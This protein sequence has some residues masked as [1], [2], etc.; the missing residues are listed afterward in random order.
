MSFVHDT[1]KVDVSGTHD[2]GLLERAVK[3]ARERRQPFSFRK[4]FNVAYSVPPKGVDRYM[5]KLNISHADLYIPQG[6]GEYMFFVYARANKNR[7][8]SIAFIRGMPDRYP[9]ALL[10]FIPGSCRPARG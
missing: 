10:V 6:G 7:R 8:L 2:L 3:R 5:F 1:S 9:Y 4:G